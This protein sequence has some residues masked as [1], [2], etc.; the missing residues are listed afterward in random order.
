MRSPPVATLSYKTGGGVIY[1][2]Y[3][4][5]FKEGGVNPVVPPSSFVDQTNGHLSPG[6]QFGPEEVDTYE[7]GARGKLFDNKVQFTTAVFYNSYKG[8]QATTTG[9]A[10]HQG[11]IE[12]I[13]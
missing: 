11:I 2:R 12:A 6:F 7:V 13:I 10:A 5:G 4:K 8:L 3:A 1:A 9:D